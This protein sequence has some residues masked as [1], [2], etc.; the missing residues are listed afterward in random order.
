VFGNVLRGLRET[1]G[2]FEQK[3]GGSATDGKQGEAE[4]TAITLYTGVITSVKSCVSRPYFCSTSENSRVHPLL[5][6][7][8]HLH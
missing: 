3:D 1:I 8:A 5:G 7:R 2:D 6:E 4:A